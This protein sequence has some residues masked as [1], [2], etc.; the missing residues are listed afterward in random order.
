MSDD[1]LMDTHM[2]CEMEK[3]HSL[4]LYQRISPL[5]ATQSRKYNL[6]FSARPNDNEL[7]IFL[8]NQSLSNVKSNKFQGL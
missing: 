3:N 2:Q 8:F 1:G 4:L 7:A 6:L 5:I